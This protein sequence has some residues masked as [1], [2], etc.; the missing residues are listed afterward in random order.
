MPREPLDLA[1]RLAYFLY[2][3]R[4]TA[5]EIVRRAL[6]GLDALAAS[7]TRRRSYSPVGRTLSGRGRVRAR[8]RTL[9]N[10]LQLLQ[11]LV[12]QAAE[13]YERRHEMGGSGPPPAVEDLVIRYLEHMARTTTQRNSFYATVGISRLVYHYSTEEAMDLYGLVVQDPDRVKDDYAFRAAKRRLLRE[14]RARF[15]AL[16]KSV[17][18]PRGEDRLEAA[19]PTPAMRLFVEESLE[20][21]TPWG[22]R[23]PVPDGLDASRDQIPALRFEGE[24][25]DQEGPVEVDRLHAVLHPPC[26]RHL[27]AALD[28]PDPKDRLVL[29][30]FRLEPAHEPRGRS[31]DRR[32][33]TALSQEERSVLEARLEDDGLAASTG[34]APEATR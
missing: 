7:Q 21:F 10:R 22:T 6:A 18:G 34:G 19:R 14:V 9:M 11:R 28:L 20:R 13:P 16:V 5:L 17:R 24:D 31:V 15:G 23:C 2:P 1:F 8:N 33:P 32:C 26:Y 27:T 25:P 30:Q 4:P 12:Y 3:D 29:P